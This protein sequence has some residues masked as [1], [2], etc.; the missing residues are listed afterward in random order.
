M[1]SG[2]DFGLIPPSPPPEASQLGAVVWIRR[3]L[4]N[5][6]LNVVITLVMGTVIL[7]AAVSLS[8]FVFS[9]E[10]R[11]EA[12]T[13]NMKLLMTFSYPREHLH[14]IWISVGIVALLIGL[15][16]AVWNA[17]GRVAPEKLQRMLIG[18][19]GLVAGLGIF[20]QP[21]AWPLM[22]GAGVVL[23]GG[24]L[25]WRQRLGKRSLDPTVPSLRVM[26]GLVALIVVIIWL[27]PIAR[28]TQVPWTIIFAVLVGSYLGGRV[29]TR[30]VGS[31]PM[32]GV[33][34]V[35]WFISFPYIYL[36]LQRRVDLD[37]DLALTFVIPAVFLVVGAILI[38]L[39]LEKL[40]R[41]AG[42]FLTGILVLAA[43]ASLIVPVAWSGW[44]SIPFLGPL[45][46][47]VLLMALATFAAGA[48][49]FA[50]GESGTRNVIL[51]WGGVVVAVAYLGT[52]FRGSTNLGMSGAPFGGLNLSIMLAITAITLAYPI[53]ITMA[54]ARTSK[55]PIFRLLSTAYI[56]LIRGVPLITVLFFANRVIPRFLPPGLAVE[57][58]VAVA[59][60]MTFFAGAYL[61][62]NIRGGLQS[63][64][65]GQVE[66]AQAVGMSTVQITALITLPQAIRTVIPALVGNA[67]ALFKDTSLVTIVGLADFLHIS[68]SVIPSQPDF[69]G[70]LKE[71]L[72]FAALV[73]WLFT[74]NFSRASQRLERKLGVGDR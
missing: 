36:V 5:S 57:A 52:V 56:E 34:L 17:G 32:R 49:T 25:A 33:V 29:A 22:V 6:T 55:M 69:L 71:P 62:E 40:P 41:D 14:R 73:Y 12:V 2:T 39:Q 8:R 45:Q 3:N 10:R 13:R 26:A 18:A 28:T 67:I 68:R 47:R 74:F 7:T 50:S 24:A 72:L 16:V 58:V 51:A 65:R 70:V 48:R 9:P 43:A 44:E 53:G 63:I 19:G 21:P 1:T 31:K 59:A 64:P 60:G 4:L 23:I 42:G 20:G 54:L 37:I 66:A 35:G 15:T 38:W 11:W 46:A 27:L 30:Q 61:A